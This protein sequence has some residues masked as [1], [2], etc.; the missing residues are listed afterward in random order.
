MFQVSSDLSLETMLSCSHVLNNDSCTTLYRNRCTITFFKHYGIKN[1]WRNY[2]QLFFKIIFI[3]GSKG[4]VL[5]ILRRTWDS[6]EKVRTQQDLGKCLSTRI[7]LQ[8]D[9]GGIDFSVAKTQ[10]N[11]GLATGHSGSF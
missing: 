6:W 5:M 7:N 2:H 3:N 1:I 8:R 10:R 11:E 9:S 4:Q